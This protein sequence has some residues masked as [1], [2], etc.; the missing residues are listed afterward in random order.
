MTSSI[1]R[2][3]GACV[4]SAG[5]SCAYLHQPLPQLFLSNKESQVTDE[6][7]ALF[8]GCTFISSLLLLLLHHLPHR[9]L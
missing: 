6:H 9:R 2:V 3:G 7:S 5:G 1:Q 4:E 8:L